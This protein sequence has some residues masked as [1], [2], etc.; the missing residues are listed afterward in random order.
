MKTKRLLLL[1]TTTGY[2]AEDFARAAQKLDVEVV[3]GTDRCRVLKDPWRDAAISMRFHRPVEAV[4]LIRKYAKT[5]PIDAV[6]AVGDKPT[7]T[8][9]LICRAL[10]LPVNS[11]QAVQKCRNKFEFRKAL[12]NSGLLAPGFHRFA[13]ERDP[14]TL[15]RHVQFP[16]VLKP[17]ALS[18]SQGVIRADNEVQ[19]REAFH[20]IRSLLETP[21]IRILK[22]PSNQYLMVEDYIEGKE[23]ALE[24]LLSKGRLRVLALFDKP[25][26]LEGPFFEETIYV[27]PSRNSK[28]MQRRIADCA[29]AAAQALGLRDGPV[30]A[31]FRTNKRGVWILELAAR[32]IGG[33]CSRTL[34]F[35]TGMSLEEVIIR[36]ALGMK[37]HSTQLESEAAGVLMLPIPGKGYLRR[38]E[39]I[40]RAKRVKGI[41]EVTITAKLGQKLVP[42][43]EGSSY[44]GFI[45]ARNTSP[46]QVEQALRA[47]HSKIV[48]ELSPELPVL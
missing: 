12:R 7:V 11:P 42:W 5:R 2:N 6:I 40:S 18:A 32:S 19:F 15:L 46:D 34:R 47:A 25:D 23:V 30:H 37:T 21:A 29:S 45:F 8:A 43:P 48:F 17:L 14:Q 41:Q 31:E 20:R 28:R 16:C 33:L 35:G 26:S 36:H 24:G 39:G 44:L 27:T 38:V 4:R 10:D 3:F 1:F 9:S 13:L 22:D